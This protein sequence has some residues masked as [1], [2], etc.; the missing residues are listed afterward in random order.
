MESTSKEGNHYH[1]S[2]SPSIESSNCILNDFLARNSPSLF[3]LEVF[4]SLGMPSI[5]FKESRTK[6]KKITSDVG[7]CIPGHPKRH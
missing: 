3:F 4:K 5:G 1:T 2:G 6:L 7:F